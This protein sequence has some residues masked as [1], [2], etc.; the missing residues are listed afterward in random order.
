[1]QAVEPDRR[2]TSRVDRAAVRRRR[3]SR[4]RRKLGVVALCALAMALLVFGLATDSPSP[5]VAEPSAP[6]PNTALTTSGDQILRAGQAWWLV[7]YNSFVWSGDCGRPT[8]KMSAEQVDAWFASMR[9]D[10]HGAVRLFFFRGWNL[11]RLDAAVESA[12]RNNIYLTI[13]I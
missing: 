8:E 6:A 13:T 11:A 5:R 7:G 4:R 1:M 12:R 2:P 9:H 3:T 10:G